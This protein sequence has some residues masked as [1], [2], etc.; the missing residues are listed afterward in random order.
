VEDAAAQTGAARARE[1]SG[2]TTRLVVGY[3]RERAADEGVTGLLRRAGID[4]PVA[5]LED[6]SV[7]SPYDERIRLFQAAIDV[8]GEPDA[9]FE[10]GAS[11]L[12]QNVSHSLVLLLRALGSPR[13][14]YRQLARAVPKFTTTSTM[15]VLDA[16]P[17]HASI[18]Y[19]LHDGYEHSRLDCRYAQGLL[20]VIP[21]F[22]GLPPARIEHSHCQSDGHDACVYEV[23][24][25]QR[26]R[27]VR[28]GARRRAGEAVELVALRGQLEALQSAAAEL[29]GSDDLDTVLDRITRMA[30]KAVLAQGY[31]L[32]V[33]GPDGVPLTRFAGIEEGRA[34]RL[35]AALRRGDDLGPSA[36]AV[37]VRS[38]RRRHGH[39][40]ALYVDGHRG[41][42]HEQDLLAAYAGHAAAALDLLLALDESRRG[43]RT[44]QALLGL[45]SDLARAGTDREVAEIAAAAVPVV[46]GAQ[47]A[48]VLLWDAAGQVVHPVAAHGLTEEEERAFFGLRLVPGHVRELDEMLAQPRARL[49]R[50]DEVDQ[51]LRELLDE[52]GSGTTAVA[53]LLADGELLGV[54]TA[55]FGAV[56]APEV[57]RALL[58]PLAGLADQTTTALQNARLV[59]QIR[60]QT[61][62]DALTGLPNRVR[63]AEA[64][65]AALATPPP[66]PAS[67]AVLF[68]D[69]DRFKSVNDTFG[70]VTGDELLRQVANRLRGAVRSGDVVARLAG[71]EF[72]LL[73][74]VV[75]SEDAAET[76]AEAVVACFERPFVVE[77]NLLDVTAS[78]GVAL[79]WDGTATADT[80]LRRADAAMYEAK[81]SGRA[82]IATASAFP[83]GDAS[84][85][86]AT[87]LQPLG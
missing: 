18:R 2:A 60:H 12:R 53:P 67:V 83:G 64:L 9:M 49:L 38:S 85:R 37:E 32:A 79:H 55:A 69:L 80:L 6:E 21:E 59:A 62:H 27:L 52:L 73:L 41:L 71:D 40:A 16:G 57:E 81:H 7:W 3:V 66:P 28:W 82:R 68:C 23:S 20:S 61:L 44:A 63:F 11:A 86:R 58:E 39:L 51:P 4:R 48:S 50:P 84:G 78:V 72:A 8:T 65:D 75:A 46:A 54:I 25:S 24:W 17:T 76:V 22:W 1:T 74:P 33:D 15:E 45:A 26:S 19:R 87:D 34:E 14:V 36:V 42:E 77:G 70:H 29:V 31:L 5:E 13:M 30:T 43:H 10:I 47:Q 35:A 56:A